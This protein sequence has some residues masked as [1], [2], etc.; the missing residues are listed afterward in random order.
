MVSC[1]YI[2][3]PVPAF[4]GNGEREMRSVGTGYS[5]DISRSPSVKAGRRRLSH[6]PTF[7]EYVIQHNH[8]TRAPLVLFAQLR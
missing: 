6:G 7:R 3:K 2:R 8:R 4:Q 1:A 5:I